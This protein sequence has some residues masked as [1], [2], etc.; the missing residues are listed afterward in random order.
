MSDNEQDLFATW[1]PGE[2]SLLEDVQRSYR[3][4]AHANRESLWRVQ[5]RLEARLQQAQ[6]E[7]RKNSFKESHIQ[8]QRKTIMDIAPQK[9]RWNRLTRTIS[10]IAAVLIV[11]A[12]VGGAIALFGPKHQSTMVGSKAPLPTAIATHIPDPGPSEVGPGASII[13]AATTT[14]RIDPNSQIALDKHQ[15]FARGAVF[16][17]TDNISTKNDTGKIVVKVYTNTILDKSV[18]TPIEAN[19]NKH[20]YI[21]LSYP[22]A[23]SGKI[24]LYWNDQLAYRLYFAVR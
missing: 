5:E 21:S 3:P 4:Y 20:G 22:V 18:E 15:V 2:H 16:Y 6:H 19:Q 14:S 8:Y 12:I 9:V 1:E 10:T 7:N 11:V 23:L 13:T 24:E 17:V